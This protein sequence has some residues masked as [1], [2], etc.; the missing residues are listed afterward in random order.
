MTFWVIICAS[1]SNR[2]PFRCVLR[3]SYLFQEDEQ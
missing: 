3:K 2:L 1:N